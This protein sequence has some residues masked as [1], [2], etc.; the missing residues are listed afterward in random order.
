M[1]SQLCNRGKASYY[2]EKVN[3][4]GGNHH[5]YDLELVNLYR[6]VVITPFVYRK[7]TKNSVDYKVSTLT[8]KQCKIL[9]T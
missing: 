1:L 3:A 6:T 7:L 9:I 4:C 2:I 8:V 5:I